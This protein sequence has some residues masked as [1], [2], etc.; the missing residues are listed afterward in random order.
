[1]PLFLK[2][3]EDNYIDAPSDP[4][5]AICMILLMALQLIVVH[6]Q[7]RWGARWFVPRRYRINPQA[8]D[9]CRSVPE[10]VLER[11]KTVSDPLEPSNFDDDITCSIC[12]NYIHYQVDEDGGLIRRDGRQLDDLELI[13][14]GR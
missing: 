1:M 14:S 5:I 8:Y 13:Q 6:F 9:Y 3:N 4:G 11:A 12:M 10:S 7:Q 2:F